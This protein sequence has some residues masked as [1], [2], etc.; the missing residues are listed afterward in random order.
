VLVREGDDEPRVLSLDRSQGGRRLSAGDELAVDRDDRERDEVG[1]ADDV[2]PDR[3][4]GRLGVGVAVQQPPT[5]GEA[6]GVRLDGARTATGAAARTRY[7]RSPRDR[8]A[9]R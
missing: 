6:V 8:N 9:R 5:G 4:P 1:R 2:E 7:D 3:R